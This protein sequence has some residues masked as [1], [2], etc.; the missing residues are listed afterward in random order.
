MSDV[1]DLKAA[2]LTIPSGID[3]AGGGAVADSWGR[4]A[5]SFAALT[6]AS[7]NPAVGDI[8]RFLA[9]THGMAWDLLVRADQLHGLINDLIATM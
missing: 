9:E 5:A 1:D 4:A 8:Q 7:N 3:R 2:L 6:Q